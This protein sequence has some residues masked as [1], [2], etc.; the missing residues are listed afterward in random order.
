MA[1]WKALKGNRTSLDTVEKHDGYIYFCIDDGSLFFDYTDAEGNL[2]RKQL[3]AKEA[4]E[5]TG[6]GI[7]TTITSSDTEIPTSKAIL[8]VLENYAAIKDV[9]K[10]PETDIAENTIYRY[11][12]TAEKFYAVTSTSKNIIKKE[13]LGTERVMQV[14]IVPVDD[15]D[16]ISS[17]TAVTNLSDNVTLYY[18][19]SEDKVY[20]YITSGLKVTL[21]I[22]GM[23]VS[24]GWQEP[25]AVIGNYAGVINN[26]EDAEYGNVYVVHEI[27]NTTH[28]AFYYNNEWFEIPT[29][30]NQEYTNPLIEASKEKFEKTPDAKINVHA[31]KML[32]SKYDRVYVEGAGNAGISGDYCLTADVMDLPLDPWS[33]SVEGEETH[34]K[35]IPIRNKDG[36]IE[37]YTDDD[38]SEH[39][40]VSKKYLA[41]T[42]EDFVRRKPDEAEDV[43]NSN[44]LAAH[45]WQ[46]DKIVVSTFAESFDSYITDETTTTEVDFSK[47]TDYADPE[48]STIIL[49]DQLPEI[50]VKTEAS[51]DN[52]LKVI[53]ENSETFLRCTHPTRWKGESDY[54]FK[55]KG[56][57]EHLA[58]IFKIRINPA[59]NIEATTRGFTFVG[60]NDLAGKGY[61][62]KDSN[63]IIS[64]TNGVYYISVGGTYTN[65]CTIPTNE[66]VNIRFELDG[67]KQNSATRLYVNDTLKNTG[68]LSANISLPKAYQL[69]IY[70]TSGSN[71]GYQGNIDIDDFYVGD[72]PASIRHNGYDS[73]LPIAYDYESYIVKDLDTETIAL[74]EKD[75]N[76][77]VKKEL[78]KEDDDRS[79]TSKYYVDSAINDIRTIDKIASIDTWVAGSYD[80]GI[81]DSGISW[82]ET[83]EFFDNNDN[84]LI[85]G[86]ISQRIPIVAGNNVEFEVDGDVVKINAVGGSSST[87]NNIYSE[88]LEYTLSD[89][90]TYYICSGPSSTFTDTKLIIASYYNGLPVKEIAAQA[91][92]RGCY[93]EDGNYDTEHPDHSG[94]IFDIVTEIIIPETIT[95]V[96]KRAFCAMM[97][98][99]SGEPYWSSTIRKIRILNDDCELE[100]GA[101]YGCQVTDIALP[102][103]L[104]IINDELLFEC[105]LTQLDIPSTVTYIG[106]RA[107]D[108]CRFKQ[109]ILPSNLTYIG[110]GAFSYCDQLEYI[111]IPKSVTT[112]GW[113]AFE[114]TGSVRIYC[115]TETKPSGWDDDWS[116]G[117][118]VEWGV[119]GNFAN[120]HDKLKG[121]N[122][123][124]SRGLEYTLSDDGTYYICT[125][126]GTCD[127]F[128][129]IIPHIYNGLPV[130]EIGSHAFCGGYGENE[131]S[132]GDPPSN[133][134]LHSERNIH[135]FVTKVVI[136]DGITKVGDMAFSTRSDSLDPSSKPST[137]TN[138]VLPD[139]ITEI[140]YGAFR[141]CYLTD[142]HIPPLVTEILEQTFETVDGNQNIII[143]KNV[144]KIAPT[145]FSS[146]CAFYC[147]AESQPEGWSDWI[148]SDFGGDVEQKFIWNFANDFFAVNSKINESNKNNSMPCNCYSQ[149]LVYTLSNDGTYYIVSGIGSCTDIELRI[150]PTYN[151]LPVKEIGDN[152]FYKN[153]SFTSVIL[154]NSILLI[155]MQAFWSCAN[156]TSI[157][158]PSGITKIDDYSFSSCKNLTSIKLPN[159]ITY[160]GCSAFS[161]CTNLTS[162]KLPNSI[163]YINDGA[164]DWCE[165]LTSIELPNSVIEIW[166]EAFNCCLNLT[167]IIIP[168][169]VVHISSSAFWAC[170]S[171]TDVYYKGTPAEWSAITLGEDNGCL[172]N[173]NIHFEY[174]DDF[175]SLHK[176]IDEYNYSQG[177]SYTLSDDGTYYIL[178]GIGTCTD[179]ELRIPPSYNGLPVKEIG[180]NAFKDDV[181][182]QISVIIPDSVTSI[183]SYAFL[184]NNRLT[185]IVIPESV[186][187]IGDAVF[188]EVYI[189][190][191]YYKGTSAKW[192][193]I[194][195]GD[196]NEELTSKIQ[197]EYADDFM[198]LN[199][200][201]GD[202]SAV[203][204]ELHNYAQNI[205]NG[206][207][208]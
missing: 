95:K 100:D 118:P 124:Y 68:I 102:K 196:R 22:A 167:N 41:T 56:S 138:I 200:K 142:V 72:I 119:S 134:T 139:S 157:N 43:Y 131:G 110:S 107:L 120:V 25:T 40:A 90:G 48:D 203:L 67:I 191:A 31:Y 19:R 29:E 180:K 1:L 164:F 11:T 133:V 71:Q 62:W 15:K 193:E 13:V 52:S 98:I 7:A 130:K 135:T 144:T 202:I 188:Y 51:A 159:S 165:N 121:L 112:I 150:P 132:C 128:E 32:N 149:G 50:Y 80:V 141:G 113:V 201:L 35:S 93:A 76:I 4:E 12:D 99:D 66:W 63:I 170:R 168:K 47:Y 136:S 59:E 127:D 45:I 143:P 181:S 206:G 140:G 20:G 184:G 89:D 152:A 69:L 30:V 175:T 36:S 16:A 125:G 96:G 108:G 146:N 42:N 147:E 194:T 84:T 199:K 153:S 94:G 8:T 39:A 37:V 172:T 9:D 117:Q 33:P 174:V 70:A 154:P 83:F 46:P 61:L 105:P 151:G 186:T 55:R 169:S 27:E 97:S 103:N 145:N 65:I 34:T 204:D 126:I 116:W 162:I 182:R 3:N 192:S 122:G 187:Y 78:T 38:S 49:E 160:I 14:V 109:V 156:L 73:L 176:K 5:L 177:L 24:T 205:I 88:G 85:E 58:L 64:N 183:G 171:L 197:F 178:S 77:L 161:H 123:N 86:N 91:F 148:A 17:P 60:T 74:R 21:A 53:K 79:A 190:T 75:G 2:Q 6:Y 173:A 208:S 198:S 57:A 129:L 163:T 111:I 189:G 28:A 26:I 92:C 166:P 54:Q 87:N 10:L 106:D 23:S 104:K 18:D 81:Q 155:G 185:S 115:E 82:G 101:F 179:I 114:E 44:V 207:K 158:F 137:I 195:I